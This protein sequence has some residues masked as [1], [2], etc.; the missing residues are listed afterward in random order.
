MLVFVAHKEM[1]AILATSVQLDVK[2]GS[3]L[4]IL[5]F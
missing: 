5:V 4:S 2:G 3:V 1:I